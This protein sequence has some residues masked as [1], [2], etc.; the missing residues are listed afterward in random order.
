MTQDRIE[1]R[2]KSRA[3]NRTQG[4]TQDRSENGPEEATEHQ[5]HPSFP[6]RR[7]CPFAPPEEYE[8]LRAEEPVSRVRMPD[9]APAWLVTRYTDVRTVLADSVF[10]S[11]VRR[12]GMPGVN[13]QIRSLARRQR[14]PFV[15]LD[16]PE[17]T[18]FRRM[19][20]P[21]FTV[22]RV[23][24]MRPGIQSV[25]DGLLD[26]LLRRTP[27]VD[28]V[29]EFALSVPSLVIC[30]LLG[31]PYDRHEF[32]Q[33]R[34]RVLLSRDSDR[35]Q[36]GA[37]WAEL[38]AYL[39]SLIDDKLR[40]PADDLMSRLVT[41]HLEPAG[42]L[43]RQDLVTT[44]ALLLNAGHETTTNMI[45][46]STVALLEHPG[47][48]AALREDPDLLPAAVEELL[49][50]LSIADLVPARVATEDVELSGT[51][52]RAGEGL[53]AL[54]GAADRDPEEFRDPD[55]LDLRRGDRRHVAFGYGVHQCIGHNL[56][57]AELEIALSSLFERV[58]GLRLAGS[59]EELSY[60]HESP[61]FGVH[62]LPVTW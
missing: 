32:F 55:T 53:I 51:T 24:A 11:D 52:I 42:E 45:S 56:A 7:R 54:L 36:A 50:Y 60:K 8:R 12:P 57:R 40:E 14:P 48:L 31:V 47:Q 38:H 2:A 4:R 18:Y 30:Q 44:C 13:P 16:P 17:H 26:G 28:L 33:D 15:R 62:E 37:A 19:L 49:R 29:E 46:L 58:P 39:D 5:N 20:I 10:S 27:P 34:A 21:E 59:V 61:V 43:T 9:G 25:V 23:R 6:M 3:E 35:D 1:S 41:D 22:R